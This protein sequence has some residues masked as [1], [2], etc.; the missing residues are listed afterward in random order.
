MSD[1]KFEQQQAKSGAGVEEPESGGR[2]RLLE[3]ADPANE[4]VSQEEARGIAHRPGDHGENCSRRIRRT[5]S[6]MVVREIL[7]IPRHE[8]GA[9]D[10]RRRPDDRVEQSQTMFLAQ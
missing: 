2:H 8:H 6:G 7:R 10:E 9:M 4:A 3:V 5:N 1:N